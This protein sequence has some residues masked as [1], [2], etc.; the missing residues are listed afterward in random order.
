MLT[1][2]AD[3]PSRLLVSDPWT[4]GLLVV[5]LIG[6]G[7]SLAFSLGYNLAKLNGL[8][9]AQADTEAT[10]KAIFA[11][12]DELSKVVPHHCQQVQRLADMSETISVA[13]ERVGQLEHW[14]QSQEK[15]AASRSE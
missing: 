8:T 2:L 12:L 11:K 6:S 13:K 1:L 14:R 4:F 3:E 9:K 15:T 5:A 7:L 10:I